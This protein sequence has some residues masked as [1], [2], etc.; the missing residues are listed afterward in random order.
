MTTRNTK[1]KACKLATPNQYD[2]L[3]ESI[4]EHKDFVPPH[5]IS[6]S[7]APSLPNNIL[8]LRDELNHIIQSTESKFQ[9]IDTDMFDISFTLLEIQQSL[10]YIS[11][12]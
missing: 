7:E 5:S 12:S 11:S 2:A 8:W 3:T 6:T 10:T 4:E 9:R 1:E